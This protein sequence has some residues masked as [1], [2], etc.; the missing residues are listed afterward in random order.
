MNSRPELS[1][2][3]VQDTAEKITALEL[4][5]E[6]EALLLAGL[7]M[8]NNRVEEATEILKSLINDGS[9]N[10]GIHRILGDIYLCANQPQLAQDFYEKVMNLSAHNRPCV[11]KLVAKTGLA[12]LESRN[13]IK[14][15]TGR[16]HQDIENE[17]NTLA[18]D[19]QESAIEAA[20]RNLSSKNMQLA[21]LLTSLTRDCPVSPC[22]DSVAGERVKSSRFASCVTC[23]I[24]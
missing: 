21:D 5:K 18:S 4:S 2:Q 11:E 1:K 14:A 23:G 13:R 9:Q 8:T 6:D 16:F 17:F 3:E 24:G 22:D 15:E 19:R 20:I 10:T 12:Q 7:Y